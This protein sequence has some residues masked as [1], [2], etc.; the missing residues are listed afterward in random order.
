MTLPATSTF[1]ILTTLTV[2]S[3][4][5]ALTE[6]KVQSCDDTPRGQI[7]SLLDKT[8][9][10]P[11]I[12]EV[13][14]G[15]GEEARK[16]LPEVAANENEPPQP[17]GE[18]IR[19]L[20]EYRSEAAE[21]LLIGWLKNAHRVCT[22]IEPLSHYHDPQLLP[23]FIGFLD[24]YQTSGKIVSPGRYEADVFVS[25]VAVSGL[26]NLTG[27]RMEQATERAVQHVPDFLYLEVER[28]Q[29]QVIGQ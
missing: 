4:S 22:A 1:G 23:D 25:D 24:N 13:I 18:A 16:I 3:L 21:Q 12:R 10:R 7:E 28:V 26:E 15:Y 20:G 5:L 19:L 14:D 8:T 11:L 6:M 17:R 29:M 27:L 9:N 2:V